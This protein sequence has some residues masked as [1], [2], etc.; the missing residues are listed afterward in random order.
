LAVVQEYRPFYLLSGTML[1]DSILDKT[2]LRSFQN[3]EKI[4]LRQL[5]GN[6]KNTAIYLDCWASWCGPCRFVNRESTENKP[7]LAEKLAVIYIS[8]DEDE[9]AW[10]QTAKDDQITENQYLLLDANNSPLNHYLKI[11]KGGI[12]RFILFNK[13]HELEILNAPRPTGRS[14][15]ELKEIIERNPEKFISE[16]P[17]A[18]NTVAK[19]EIP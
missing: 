9:S 4:T 18:K 5:L 14:F 10:L 16:K 8:V 13:N 11:R 1:P 7:Y 15:E 2:Y 3:N 17:A 19:K 12:P 6:Y